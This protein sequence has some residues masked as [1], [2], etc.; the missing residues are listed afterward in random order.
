MPKGIYKVK[1][2]DSDVASGKAQVFIAGELQE[3]NLLDVDEPLVAAELFAYGVVMYAKKTGLSFAEIAD[4][5]GPLFAPVKRGRKSISDEI[6]ERYEKEY[7]EPLTETS[8]K[9]RVAYIRAVVR[10]EKARSKVN[11]SDIPL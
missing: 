7:N 11:K 4:L 1:S 5:K 10:F 2:V 6:A 3:V 8:D 9:A